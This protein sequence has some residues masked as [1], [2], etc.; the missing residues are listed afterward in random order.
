MWWY[1]H[2]EPRKKR[3]AGD[4]LKLTPCGLRGMD[5]CVCMCWLLACLPRMVIDSLGFGEVVRLF[6]LSGIL[7][8]VFSFFLLLLLYFSK[9]NNSLLGEHLARSRLLSKSRKI[10]FFIIW[11]NKEIVLYWIKY[12]Q[13]CSL[14]CVFSNWSSSVW[15]EIYVPF[16]NSFKLSSWVKKTGRR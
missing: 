11:L 4:V 3:G 16:K 15:K 6:E 12:W 8:F 9:C 14:L 10:S 5:G 1:L 7:T 13:F 2:H